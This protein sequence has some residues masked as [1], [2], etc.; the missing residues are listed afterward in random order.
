MISWIYYFETGSANRGDSLD[1]IIDEENR[2]TKDFLILVSSK[3]S[4]WQFFVILY[5]ILDFKMMLICLYLV[6]HPEWYFE[7]FWIEIYFK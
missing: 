5:L 7:R 1:R 3:I 4:L 2:S 6:L